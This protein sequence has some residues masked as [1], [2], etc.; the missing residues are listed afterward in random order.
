MQENGKKPQAQDAGRELVTVYK[1]Q[2][3][4][5]G[6]GQTL[7]QGPRVVWVNICRDV[8]SWTRQSPEQPIAMVEPALV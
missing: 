4:H 7:G 5:K 3:F 6:F 2:N 1:A 8:H